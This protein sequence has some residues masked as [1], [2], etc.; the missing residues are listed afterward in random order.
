MMQRQR[1]PARN[2]QV[3]TREGPGEAHGRAKRTQP[4]FTSI[5]SHAWKCIYKRLLRALIIPHTHV[6]STCHD[7]TRHVRRLG[8]HTGVHMRPTESLDPSFLINLHLHVHALPP[9]VMPSLSIIACHPAPTGGCIPTM[10][11]GST[12]QRRIYSSCWPIIQTG[13]TTALGF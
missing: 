13:P 6:N 10:S 8:L 5:S 2:R 7:T 4:D 12:L 11:E 9:T 3:K 1:N